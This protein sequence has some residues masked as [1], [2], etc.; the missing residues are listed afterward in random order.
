[1][2]KEP[3]LKCNRNVNKNH[4]AVCCDICNRWV[5]I[6]CNFFNPIDYKRL[7][8]DPLPFF[9]I[10]CISEMLPFEKVTNNEFYSF[11][12]R[13]SIFPDNYES[14]ISRQLSPQIQEHVKKLNSLFQNP[15]CEDSDN[16]VSPIDCN[17]YDPEEFDNAKF[18]SSKSFSILHLNIH[19][20]QKH[21]DTLRILIKSMESKSF[22]FNIIAISESKLKKTI[23]PLVDI[24]I[25]NYHVPVSTPSEGSK[26][27]V[28]FYIHS[29]LEFKPRPDLEIYES[30]TLESSFIEIINSK[31][32][33]DI[34][35]VIYRH[36]SMPL[37][38]F[39]E[40]Y[41]RSLIFNLSQEKNK[42]IH[43]AGD[44]NV[45]LLNLSHSASSEYFEIMCSN[46]LLPS[47]SL[48]T[49]LNISDKDTLID[50]IFTNSFNPD[51]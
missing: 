10:N 24:K 21:I 4:R 7:Q 32:S 41:L 2:P 34:V 44:F 5:H 30:R 40:N 13:G 17:Y 46:H 25:D 9:C 22:E 28:L 27:G 43:I 45:D 23:S 31:K 16:E 6:K 48:P 39:N 37:E 47:I 29:K 14:T 51:T 19:S 50:K 11:I 38:H 20:I 26:G 8:H 15:T 36:P 3:C 1:M 35:G 42:N 33:N 49:K 12:T 18:D